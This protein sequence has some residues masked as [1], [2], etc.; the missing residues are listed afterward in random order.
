MGIIDRLGFEKGRYNTL[1]FDYRKISAATE[2]H[3][4]TVMKMDECIDSLREATIVY[5]VDAHKGYW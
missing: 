2:R 3:A 5:T 1:F 4:Y